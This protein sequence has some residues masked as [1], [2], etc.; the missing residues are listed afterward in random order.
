MARGS[1]YN[2]A[3]LSFQNSLYND[4]TKSLSDENASI[5]ARVANAQ[6]NLDK[7]NSRISELAQF[8]D[9]P[10]GQRFTV[11][12]ANRIAIEQANLDQQG[13]PSVQTGW[14]NKVSKERGKGPKPFNLSIHRDIT[15]E[16]SSGQS[17][18][19]KAKL[20]K[21]MA[22]NSEEG[23]AAAADAYMEHFTGKETNL[24]PSENV[25]AEQAV[26]NAA[27]VLRSFGEGEQE[28]RKVI[29]KKIKELYDDAEEGEIF[30][31]VLMAE[32][33]FREA[34]P[35]KGLA[36]YNAR[37]NKQQEE[38]SGPTYT[39]SF[40]TYGQT[41]RK[42]GETPVIE[43][44]EYTG[45]FEQSQSELATLRQ[46]RED[47][48]DELERLFAMRHPDVMKSAGE[49]FREQAPIY[50]EKSR[51]AKNLA[52]EFAD[53]LAMERMGGKPED[54]LV[55]TPLENID[56]S[57]YS[58]LDMSTLPQA[59]RR[60]AQQ[61]QLMQQRMGSLADIQAKRPM[62]DT[63]KNFGVQR[64][65][66]RKQRGSIV[67]RVR[68]ER[69]MLESQRQEKLRAQEAANRA[70]SREEEG[71]QNAENR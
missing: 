41:T 39:D 31:G 58:Q 63:V 61:A 21:M 2:L 1:I 8:V 12:Q 45:E 44:A 9:D 18:D 19:A 25:D 51:R 68:Q 38:G 28:A 29:E 30:A 10:A 42:L 69:A 5:E 17:V 23:I 64:G 50:E 67:E 32:K 40:S 59:T 26:V 36:E 22:E 48:Q 7:L 14:S 54:L 71:G 65:F 57:M 34:P 4:I 52:Q 35:G 15:E 16:L 37:L 53:A 6:A 56:P 27:A 24:Y 66:S 11:E 46:Q 70:A 20:K 49:L 33:V 3:Y 60:L 55:G 43:G 47:A 62:T 13:R